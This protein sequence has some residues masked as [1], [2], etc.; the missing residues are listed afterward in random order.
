MPTRCTTK[1]PLALAQVALSIARR[2]LPAFSCPKSR[3]DFT[4]PQLFTLL[5]LRQFLRQDYRGFV[6]LLR[7]WSD[8][9]QVLGLTKIPHYTTLQKA[10]QRLLKKTASTTFWT[11]SSPGRANTATSSNPSPPPST[12][13]VWNPLTSAAIS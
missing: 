1:S 5:V 13:A 3:H 7:E 2:A 11:P 9:R 4:Q 8:L 10:E 6:Q 12:P